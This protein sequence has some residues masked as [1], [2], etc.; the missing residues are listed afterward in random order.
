MAS[1]PS[2]PP[3]PMPSASSFST[4]SENSRTTVSASPSKSSSSLVIL[5]AEPSDSGVYL[6]SPSNTKPAAVAVHV[7][8]GETSHMRLA[9]DTLSGAQIHLHSSQ[10][11]WRSNDRATYDDCFPH[12]FETNEICRLSILFEALLS[13]GW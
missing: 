9:I 5:R 3:L 4:L 10:S 2:P 8:Q 1:T 6:C 13:V 7:L 11:S 12:D